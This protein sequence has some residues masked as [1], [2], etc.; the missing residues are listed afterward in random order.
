MQY[1]LKRAD[2]HIGTRCPRFVRAFWSIPSLS[3]R[4]R[5]PDAERT[6]SADYQPGSQIMEGS[7]AT[8]CFNLLVPQRSLEVLAQRLAEKARVRAIKAVR[9][10]VTSE[11]LT[12]KLSWRES[13][14]HWQ[15]CGAPSAQHESTA[16]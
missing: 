6:R 11:M 10:T 8:V 13:M 4:V 5:I 2:R 1:L 15:Q 14:K 16:V 12:W 7:G 9:L 3:L